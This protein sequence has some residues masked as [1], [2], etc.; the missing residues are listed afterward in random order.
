[1]QLIAVVSDRSKGEG[2]GPQ[3]YTGIKMKV[4]APMPEVGRLSRPDQLEAKL[5][6]L[7]DL[8]CWEIDSRTCPSLLSCDYFHIHTFHPQSLKQFEGKSVYFVAATLRP[9]TMYGQT[10]CWMHPTIKYIAWQV[11]HATRLLKTRW[12]VT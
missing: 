12:V 2:V 10:N 7:N 9:E 5:L 3:E 6:A 1:M 11:R 4:I 8:S